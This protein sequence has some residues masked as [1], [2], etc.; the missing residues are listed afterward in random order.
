M[1]KLLLLFLLSAS[2][3]FAQNT[4][5]TISVTPDVYDGLTIFS[6]NTKTFLLDNCGR[7]VNEWDSAYL[8]GHS[9]YLLPNGNIIRAGRKD[10]SSIIFGGTGGIVEMFDWDGNLVWEFDYSTDEHRLHHDIFPMP[11]GNILMLAAERIPRADAIQAGRDPAL[12]D[13]D[14]YAETI[15]EVEPLENNGFNIVWKWDVSD[16]LIQDFD[17]TKDNFG[18]VADNFRKIDVN[19]RNSNNNGANWL[20]VNSIQYYEDLDQIVISSRNLSEI[21]IIDHSTTTAEAATDSGGTYGHGGDFLYRWGNPQ[22][23]DKGTEDDRV[24]YGQHYP[25]FIPSGLQDAGKIILFNNGNGRVPTFSEV[26]IID[27]PTTAP[28][29]YEYD[30]V[31]PYGPTVPDFTYEE[32]NDFFSA[33]LSSAIR[34]PNGNIL[35]CEGAE[36]H[37]F[38]LDA[39]DNIVWD[40][41]L[42][43]HNQNGNIVA[44]G[45]PRPTFGHSTFRALKYPIN[46]AGFSGRDLTPGDPIET[47]FNLDACAPLSTE[48]IELSQAKIYPNPV[49][50]S[51]ITVETSLTID[52][53]EMYNILGKRVG[54]NTATNKFDMS[55]LRSGVYIL[56]IFSGESVS[57]Q[58]VIKR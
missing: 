4:V 48:Q 46:Y 17:N 15:L 25:H 28:G 45:D 2:S 32:P 11:N 47:N 52:R 5:G 27:P 21:W 51:Y 39:S 20:H 30:N 49:N 19:F 3:L 12:L 23:Y 43:M 44:Q 56:K 31:N 26:M 7:V 36:G 18:V 37:F 54:A 42:P 50:D 14:L 29:V 1:R 58:K 22:S 55:N 57:S 40:Y 41:F 24:L 13:D 38:E 53:M 34:L 35:V 9:V 10:T 33:I 6:V 16:H 8:P